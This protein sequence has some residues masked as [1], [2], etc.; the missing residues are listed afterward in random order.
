MSTNHHQL[1][2]VEGLREKLHPYK[3]KAVGLVVAESP[4]KDMGPNDYAFPAVNGKFLHR[5]SQQV[6]SLGFPKEPFVNSCRINAVPYQKPDTRK[7]LSKAIARIRVETALNELPDIQWIILLGKYAEAGATG[8]WPGL[9]KVKM[10]GGRR[11]AGLAHP[12]WYCYQPTNAGNDN[13]GAGNDNR[14][15]DCADTLHMVFKER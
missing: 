3:G 12:R 2:L 6:L 9:H 11:V 4:A 8:F 10:V 15:K 7:E 5:A 1:A 13:C 14:R